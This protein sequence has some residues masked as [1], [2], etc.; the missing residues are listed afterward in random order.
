M[1]F[2]RSHAILTLYIE[3]H[4]F[5]SHPATTAP[6]TNATT[7]STANPLSSTP[8]QCVVSEK[9]QPPA[10]K[11]SQGTP[12]LESCGD[13]TVRHNGAS[14]GFLSGSGGET[15]VESSQAL[16]LTPSNFTELAGVSQIL[17][18]DSY[19]TGSAEQGDIDS[20]DRDQLNPLRDGDIDSKRTPPAKTQLL[21]GSGR[22]LWTALSPDLSKD[23]VLSSAIT[24]SPISSSTAAAAA[25]AAR[26]TSS[27]AAATKA[28]GTILSPTSPNNHQYNANS[29]AKFSA[30]SAAAAEAGAAADIATSDVCIGRLHLVD[31]A[32][33]DR[34]E[35]TGAVKDTLK[36]SQYINASLSAFG[37]FYIN[38]NNKFII[39]NP[40]HPSICILY[41][42]RCVLCPV[43][44]CFPDSIHF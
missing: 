19:S 6:I 39:S 9:L 3:R 25:V 4:G 43:R 31:L 38:K 23:E 26:T 8:S 27:A 36:E 18:A 14:S 33:F 37:K 11:P 13:Y 44:P 30:E 15:T 40:L 28:T 24:P 5:H 2:F 20:E 34:L 1:M 35:H 12:P 41:A 32:G 42:F 16:I 29:S 17:R 22:E 10:S 21:Q 7:V